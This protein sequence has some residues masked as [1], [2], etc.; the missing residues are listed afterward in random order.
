M[1]L[2]HGSDHIIE[3][4]QFGS[5]KIYNDYGRGFYCTDSLEMAK[6]WAV[7]AKKDGFANIYYFVPDELFVLNLTDSKFNILHWLTIL[8]QNRTFETSSVLATEAKEYLIQNFYIEYSNADV[9]VGY[10]ANDSY[11]SF[12]QD[13]LNGAISYRQL[14]NAIKLG[15][16]GIQT[17]LKSKNAF[18]KINYIGFELADK[19]EWYAR[20]MQRDKSARSD[21]FNIDESRRQKGD[22]YIT[23]ILDEEIKQDD[24]RLR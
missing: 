9:I 21:Y 16:F 8:I 12:V 18:E 11:F 22:L 4:P 2:Y 1:Q 23:Q 14:G 6:E 10:R 3:K 15:K 24:C 19:N 20:K 13:F 7:T 17:V 5:G